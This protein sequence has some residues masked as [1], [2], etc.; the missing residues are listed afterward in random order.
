MW[1][2]WYGFLFCFVLASNH[3]VTTHNFIGCGRDV[4]GLDDCQI[5]LMHADHFHANVALVRVVVPEIVMLHSAPVIHVDQADGC[6][7]VDFDF[8][9]P[10][11]LKVTKC[12]IMFRT[13][14]Q[15]K[16]S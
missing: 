10:T 8:A 13:N 11:N 6:Q 9:L 16:C 14:V 12:E 5:N 1:T 15:T 4:T 2:L 3:L 7:L